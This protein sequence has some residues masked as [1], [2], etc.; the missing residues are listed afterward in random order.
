MRIILVILVLIIIAIPTAAQTC[1]TYLPCG[2]VPWGLP[3]FPGLRSPTPVVLSDA[4]NPLV[5]ATS[6][7]GSTATSPTTFITPTPFLD[8]SA[9]TDNVATLEAMFDATDIPVLNAEGTPV[10]LENTIATD[11]ELFFAYAKGITAN[12]FGVFA[13]LVN[14]IVFT[15]LFSIFFAVVRMALPVLAVIFGAIR[16]I[17]QFLL[18]FIPG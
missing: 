16:K 15:F 9:F 6:T 10:S 7:P 4:G 17:I 1:G 12:S 14:F 2:N 5:V 3:Q 13:P 11:G 18:D 8:A